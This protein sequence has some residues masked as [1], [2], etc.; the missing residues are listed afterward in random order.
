MRVALRGAAVEAGRAER[1]LE[2]AGGRD[3]VHGAV[4]PAGQAVLGSP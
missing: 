3:P 1:L 2:R 4:E